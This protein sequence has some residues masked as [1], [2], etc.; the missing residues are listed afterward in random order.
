MFVEY[1]HGKKDAAE[2][3]INDFHDYWSNLENKT[4][5]HR[6]LPKTH[7]KR[8]LADI[9]TKERHPEGYGSSRWI[10]NNEILAATQACV[11]PI[12]YSPKKVKTSKSSSSSSLKK[13]IS[14]P[15]NDSENGNG[16]SSPSRISPRILKTPLKLFAEQTSSDPSCHASA[17]STA[18][19]AT[20]DI[21]QEEQHDDNNNEDAEEEEEEEKGIADERQQHEQQ[22]NDNDIDDSDNDER[23]HD[24]EDEDSDNG[25]IYGQKQNI[26]KKKNGSSPKSMHTEK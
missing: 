10:V 16:G 9:S 6:I 12:V 1:I 17:T 23:D 15:A 3:I 22:Q 2:K 25:S 24:E 18:N 7:I 14:S 8:K 11:D 5:S 13:K 21:E 26:C 4:S 20:K 19:V